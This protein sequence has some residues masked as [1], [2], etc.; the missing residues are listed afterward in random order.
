MIAIEIETHLLPCG[1]SVRANGPAAFGDDR[2]ESLLYS[3]SIALVIA[4]ADVF[5]NPMIIQIGKG[6]FGQS[7]ITK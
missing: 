4:H 6:I 3:V 5:N 1:A 7:V 2:Q